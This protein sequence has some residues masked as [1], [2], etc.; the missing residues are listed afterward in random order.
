MTIS[1]EQYPWNEELQCRYMSWMADDLTTLILKTPDQYNKCD[2][3]GCIRVAKNIM[4]EVTKIVVMEG[5]KKGSVYTKRGV[6]WTSG[7]EF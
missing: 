3:A 1:T 7:M 6:K 4:P 2:M 5:A